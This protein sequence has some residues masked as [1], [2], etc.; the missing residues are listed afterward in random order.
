M[1]TVMISVSI[2][3]FKRATWRGARLA[4]SAT[5]STHSGQV[6]SRTDVTRPRSLT[7]VSPRASARAHP[8]VPSRRPPNPHSL[9]RGP[10][11]LPLDTPV[12]RAFETHHHHLPV[13]QT[14][15]WASH[16]PYLELLD[17][18]FSLSRAAWIPCVIAWDPET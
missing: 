14:R 7:S 4:F 2:C 12:I 11:V 9:V 6:E 17:A 18:Y 10:G 15:R 5:H 13:P 8:S 1:W 16:D 3:S